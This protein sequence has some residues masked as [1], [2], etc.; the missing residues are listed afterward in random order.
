MSPVSP[1]KI[2]SFY[3]VLPSLFAYIR[4]VVSEF[5]IKFENSMADAIEK[6]FK[7]N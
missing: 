5:F 2:N 7:S 1:C 4:I 3:T 6:Y